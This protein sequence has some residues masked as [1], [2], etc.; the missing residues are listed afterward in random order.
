M[1]A[2][3][4]KKNRTDVPLAHGR[5]EFR[6]CEFIEVVLMSRPYFCFL[7]Y[8]QAALEHCFGVNYSSSSVL[9]CVKILP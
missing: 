2:Q 1:K 6:A 4:L 3:V 9:V 8:G 7:K 5:P